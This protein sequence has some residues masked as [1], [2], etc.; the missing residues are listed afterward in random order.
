MKSARLIVKKEGEMVSKVGLPVG[1]RVTLGR[2]EQADLRVE[3]PSVSRVHLKLIFDGEA[4]TAED[5]ASAHGTKYNGKPLK[6]HEKVT[7]VD[8]DVLSLGA[9]SRSYHISITGAEG[10]AK[11]KA[12]DALAGAR[13]SSSAA[14]AGA[15]ASSAKRSRTG[16]R[17]AL[18]H[19]RTHQHSHARTHQHSH[20]RRSIVL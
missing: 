20:A 10:A 14:N 5:N 15:S 1:K 12:E 18:M 16:A 17:Q 8:G 6:A 13:A 4:I 19:A 9:S 11:R 3:H 2:N 7:L